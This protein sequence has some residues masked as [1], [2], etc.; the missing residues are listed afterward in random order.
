MTVAGPSVAA[1]SLLV[2]TASL[3]AVAAAQGAL[4]PAASG[5]PALSLA[6]S[7]AAPTFDLVE[8]DVP[9]G[10]HPHDVAPA[11]DGGVWYTSQQNGTLGLLDPVTG[12]VSE[13]PIRGWLTTARCHRGPGR[14]ALDH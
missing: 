8:F 3:L 14:R 4:A 7:P 5:M 10:S 12:R 11:L 1:S 6:S 2:L 13:I 9:S